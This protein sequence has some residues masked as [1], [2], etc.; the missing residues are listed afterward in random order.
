MGIEGSKDRG[1]A[2]CCFWKWRSS[3]I[4]YWLCIGWTEFAEVQRGD[5][6]L[7]LL[8]VWCQYG[9]SGTE[10]ATRGR[11]TSGRRKEESWGGCQKETPRGGS[12]SS[13]AE[14]KGGGRGGCV[15]EERGGRSCGFE[16]EVR[17]RNRSSHKTKAIG[18]SSCEVEVRRRSCSSRKAEITRRGSS[19]CS[20]EIRRRQSQRAA[21]STSGESKT[22][23]RRGI[24][25]R[26]K[27][28]SKW[29][30]Y[31]L[32][33]GLWKQ[34]IKSNKRIALTNWRIRWNTNSSNSCWSNSGRSN[35]L[36]V[37]QAISSPEVAKRCQAGSE[38]TSQKCGQHHD[39]RPWLQASL[40][41]VAGCSIRQL[42]P[43]NIE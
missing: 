1:T 37:H 39:D 28:K 38:R 15:K 8:E 36:V 41:S 3:R 5:Q 7:V 33:G 42:A 29:L 34:Q 27:R 22:N 26:V 35:S 21:T 11:S 43:D 31:R 10:E 40:H 12:C 6:G 24:E 32:A 25:I 9:G 19:S 16:K 18:R 23:T 20:Q 4:C 13:S 17:G 30:E 14:E 2:L